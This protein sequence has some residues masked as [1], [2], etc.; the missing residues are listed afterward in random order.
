V[1]KTIEIN[2]EQFYLETVTGIALSAERKRVEHRKLKISGG[3]RGYVVGGI[4]QLDPI[5]IEEEI[6]EEKLQ[7]FVLLELD[8]TEREFQFRNEEYSVDIRPGKI[9][10]VV[11]GTKTPSG[12]KVPYIVSNH[13]SRRSGTLEAFA[14][15]VA[16]SN[17][18][19]VLVVA[20]GLLLAF[21]LSLPWY[22][23]PMLAAAALGANYLYFIKFK[24]RV[25]AGQYL[26]SDECRTFLRGL[27]KNDDAYR[28]MI[29]QTAQVEPA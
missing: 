27:R 5:E 29:G 13:N 11:L 23:Y 16:M 10:T 1:E 3:D 4:V 17:L 14:D 25:T 24:Q 18:W 19:M 15:A 21:L 2:K 8:G 22:G 6:T 7:N 28:R 20:A 26:D 12:K 9:V